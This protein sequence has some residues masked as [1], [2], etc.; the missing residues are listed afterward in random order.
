M[1]PSRRISPLSRQAIA[2][3]CAPRTGSVLL[4]VLVVVAL[5]SLGAYT[6]S[7]F[8]IV[9][10]Q[11]TSQYG[12]EVQARG[13]ADSGIELAASLLVQ[14]REQNPES[15]YHN[16]EWFQGVLMRDSG[17]AKGRGRFSVVSPVE[18]DPSGRTI[19]FGMIDE[20]ARLNVNTLFKLG[21]DA[22]AARALLESLPEMTPD[23]ADAILDF[24]DTDTTAR[25]FGCEDEYYATL[26]PPY[27]TKNGPLDSLDELLLVR[28]V[29][30]ELLFGEDANRNGLLDPNENDG[31]ASPP[32]DNADGILQRGWSAYLTIHSRELNQRSDG[33]QRINVNQNALADLYDAILP[34]FDEDTAKF[35]IAYRMSGPSTNASAGASS[36]SGSNATVGRSSVGRSGSGGTRTQSQSVGGQ[37]QNM[38]AQGSGQTTTRQNVQQQGAGQGVQQMAN[39]IS[40]AVFN[41][42]GT[43]TRGGIDVTNGGSVQINSLF[44]LID[45]QVQVT[46]SGSPTTLKSPW[47]SDPGSMKGYLPKMMDNLTTRADQ[48]IEGRININQA[49]REVLLGLPG[50]TESLADQIVAG[51]AMAMDGSALSSQQS[52]RVTTGWLVTDGLIDL[53]TMRALDPY[54]TARGDVFRMQ[55]VGFF[56]LGGPV[57]R[58]EAVIDA[59]QDPPQVVFV[60]D[61]TDLG[62]GYTPQLLT[63]GADSAR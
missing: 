30:P 31:A 44:E 58:I 25:E 32:M 27:Q 5:L 13:F 51:Q 37:V 21:L 28:G 2:S 29:T 14:R 41:S 24:I 43:V 9:E 4:I 47:T 19:R 20:S 3:G 26:S 35:I 55:S 59:T 34:I 6:F 10:A 33:E 7:E 62:R 11:S 56:E 22:N 54:I 49:H 38:A 60:R 63:L 8:M 61:L 40:R 1:R 23:V 36:S 42:G 46:V 16:P 52:D 15:Y 45:V 48:Y 39:N 18:S 17:A 12:K 53:T 50:M 57:S